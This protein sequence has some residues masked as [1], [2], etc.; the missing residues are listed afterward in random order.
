MLAN[1]LCW[2]I[3]FGIIFSKSVNREDLYI[4]MLLAIGFILVGTISKFVDYYREIHRD[5]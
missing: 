2:V 4:K 1:M 3:A 5:K